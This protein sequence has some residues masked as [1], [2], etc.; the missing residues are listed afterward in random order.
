MHNR[1]NLGGPCHRMLQAL[2]CHTV[3]GSDWQ[4]NGEI[5]KGPLNPKTTLW[6]KKHLGSGG[7]F[8]TRIITC[9]PCS[10]ICCQ[11]CFGPFTAVKCPAAPHRLQVPPTLPACWLTFLNAR[12]KASSKRMGWDRRVSRLTRM[13]AGNNRTAVVSSLLCW[14]VVYKICPGESAGQDSLS[15]SARAAMWHE[16]TTACFPTG[17][18]NAPTSLCCSLGQGLLQALNHF[19]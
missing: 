7:V 2:K 1:Q 15:S 8:Q 10:Y 17:R 4:I 11:T 6:T 18:R 16:H 5:Y 3:L 14:G 19:L 12:G 13:F 9:L